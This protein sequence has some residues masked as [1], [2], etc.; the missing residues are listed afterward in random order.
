VSTPVDTEAERHRLEGELLVD[1]VRTA[2]PIGA[3]PSPS[4]APVLRRPCH[5]LPHLACRRQ[6]TLSNLAVFLLKNE[7]AAEAGPANLRMLSMADT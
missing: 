1:T 3:A 4:R 5:P 2:R 6:S 7:G